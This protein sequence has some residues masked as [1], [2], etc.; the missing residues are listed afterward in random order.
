MT[1]SFRRQLVKAEL[2]TTILA[3]QLM[4]LDLEAEVPLEMAPQNQL[5]CVTSS[6]FFTSIAITI[7]FP[8]SE[9]ISRAEDC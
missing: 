1:S 3:I 7:T 9:V 6:L 2:K 4:K 5:I 8:S